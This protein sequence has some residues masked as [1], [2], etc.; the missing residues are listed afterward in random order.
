MHDFCFTI[1]Y[2]LIL[3]CGGIFGY[4]HKGST[5]SLGGGVEGGECY[6]KEGYYRNFRSN[7]G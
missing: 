5:A 7:Y 1:P 4:V 3:V 2:G 6:I